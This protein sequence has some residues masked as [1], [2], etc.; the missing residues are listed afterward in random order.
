MWVGGRRLVQVSIKLIAKSQLPIPWFQPWAKHSRKPETRNPQP[1]ETNIEKRPGNFLQITLIIRFSLI[2]ASII[3]KRLILTLFTLSISVLLSAQ[4]VRNSIVE[5]RS[6]YNT[7]NGQL[8]I[9]WP[10]DAAAVGYDISTKDKN[11]YAWNALMSLPG[12]DSSF[13]LPNYIPGQKFDVYVKKR[14]ASNQAHGYIHVGYHIPLSNENPILLLVIDSNY[15]QP[16]SSEIERYI[17]DLELENW[18]VH[19]HY[20]QR[21]DSVQKVKRWIVEEWKADSN[22]VKSV[23]LLGRVPVPYSGN[24]TPDV[25]NDHR[26]AWP[27]DVYYVTF[28]L[29]WTDLTVNNASAA[30]PENRNIPGDNKFDQDYIW[31]ALSKIPLGRID[32]TNMPAFGNDTF[33]MKRY[34]DK[35]HAYRTG[36]LKVKHRGLIDDNFGV[37][38]SEAFAANAWRDYS[39]LF[40]SEVYAQDY[41]SSMRDSSFLFSYGCG[42][43]SYTGASGIG[44]ST[45]F[46][47]DSL[48][49]PFTS[50]FGSYFGDWDN[51]N[52]FL[53][54]P[55]ASKGWG[56]VS[57]WAGRPHWNYHHAS[58]NEPVGFAVVQAQNSYPTYE[59]GTAGTFVHIA[60]MGDPSL[61]F[62]VLAPP[63]QFEL[64]D[65]CLGG[66][67][68]LRWKAEDADSVHIWSRLPGGIWQLEGSYR[69]DDTTIFRVLPIGDREYQ[70]QAT[71]WILNPSGYFQIASHPAFFQ[72]T[73]NPP[74]A[75]QIIISSTAECEGEVIYFNAGSVAPND[76]T[77][78]YLNGNL[79]TTSSN[80]TFSQLTAGSYNLL[81][82]QTNPSGCW[83][84][85]NVSFTIHPKASLDSFQIQLV[86]NNI[87]CER[88]NNT[89]SLSGFT[90]S[91]PTRALI[92]WGDSSSHLD[93]VIQNGFQIAKTYNQA[94]MF[95]GRIYLSNNNQTC[96]NQDSFVLEV[97]EKPTS[98]INT[99]AAFLCEG[100]SLRYTL[101]STDILQ[102]IDWYLNNQLINSSNYNGWIQ[103]NGTQSNRLVVVIANNHSC[104]DSS[105]FLFEM[106]P[107]PQPQI[108]SIDKISPE[109]ACDRHNNVFELNIRPAT[110][111]LRT[112]ITWEAGSQPFD[113]VHTVDLQ[114]THTYTSAGVYEIT[115]LFADSS[116][117]CMVEEKL[118]LEVS[119]RPALNPIT[120]NAFTLKENNPIPFQAGYFADLQYQWNASN[121]VTLQTGDSSHKVIADLSSLDSG[122]HRIWLIMQN[123][124]GCVSD[125]SFAEISLALGSGF[126]NEQLWQAY[127]NPGSGVVQIR[128]TEAVEISNWILLDA[129]G[130]Q[131]SPLINQL[132]PESYEINFST[133]SSGTYVLI[134]DS[135]DQRY[136]KRLVKK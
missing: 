127:P 50:L 98:Q 64:N 94:G 117:N 84:T 43:G 27:A 123:D 56:L 49:N 26:G 73:V 55:L 120:P 28:D 25:H 129:T 93:T 81:L 22:R 92:Y 20:V 2:F 23:V 32:L 68:N 11:Q 114:I 125:T 83:D 103:H 90:S 39:T 134:A 17:Q 37:Q 41:F 136:M 69:A 35:N 18:E 62:H 61:R 112:R 133:L 111:P 65:L 110:T 118:E 97:K 19:T 48:L 79:E 21:T 63:S 7:S 121:G 101:V 124:S 16:L 57:G 4:A 135:K 30:R 66:S 58:L 14:R 85:A 42:A 91:Y 122:L 76:S 102:S 54:A 104:L 130:K 78:W 113:T 70:L 6:H 132:S 59:A 9:F 47:N 24:I 15:T 3:M 31:P 109:P 12:T 52:N 5:L 38:G 96:F 128:F 89:F 53:R 67:Y 105:E 126:I 131:I 107:N 45:N 40:G 72:T 51:A 46:V 36:Q 10:K 13:V 100:D 106:F 29:N 80:G 77:L 88:S 116:G 99:T 95:K 33:L 60:M 34:F 108:L 71:R 115:L 86:G 44:N 1:T 74:L 87:A 119:E 75:A 82:R 8:T